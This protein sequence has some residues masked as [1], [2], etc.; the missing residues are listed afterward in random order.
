MFNSQTTKTFVLANALN[1]IQVNPPHIPEYPFLASAVDEDISS[2]LQDGETFD[3]ISS[4]FLSEDDVNQTC[5][6][7]SGQSRCSQGTQRNT[8]LA[9]SRYFSLSLK[10][11]PP[12][13][14]SNPSVINAATSLNPILGWHKAGSFLSSKGFPPLVSSTSLWCSSKMLSGSLNSA[15][16]CSQGTHRNTWLA[17]SRYFSSKVFPP[18]V[19]S[20]CLWCS[21]KNLSGSWNLA[22][23]CKVVKRFAARERNP[24][25]GWHRAGTSLLSKFSPKG[26]LVGFP[27]WVTWL[28]PSRYFSL[29][30]G[31]GLS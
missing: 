22:I 3:D 6:Q 24:I 29:V 9:P 16:F 10:G 11:F 14:F 8:W 18:W 2:P 13:G 28:A 15:S 19:Y 23:L 5:C 26:F 31:F 12:M 20:T 7:E 17:L 21:P 4:V 30:K 25:I 27:L 1:Q